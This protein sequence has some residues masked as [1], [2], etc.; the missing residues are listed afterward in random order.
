MVLQLGGQERTLSF[1]KT[2]ILKHLDR[3]I[4]DFDLLDVSIFS[5]FGKAYQSVVYL[6][7][8]GLLAS[9]EKDL[10]KERVEEWVDELDTDLIRD[11]QYRGYSIITGKSVDELKNLEAQVMNGVEKALS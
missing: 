8:A 9:G 4:G 3:I 2:K 1:G 7:W 10:T 5:N 11:I 6:V